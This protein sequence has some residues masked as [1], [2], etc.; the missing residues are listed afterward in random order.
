MAHTITQLV[1]VLNKLKDK[2]LTEDKDLSNISY[3][4]LE[5]LDNITE[6]EKL[7]ILQYGAALKNHRVTSFLQNSKSNKKGGNK[8]GI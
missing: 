5:D 7:I 8:D 2:N 3:D 6:Y 4:K 1:R